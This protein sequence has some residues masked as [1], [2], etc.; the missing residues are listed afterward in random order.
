MLVDG[1]GDDR[2]AAT[3]Y[4]QGAGFFGIG[5]LVDDGGDDRYDAMTFAQA[6]GATGGL[7]ALLEERG[8]DTYV[9]AG[10]PRDFRE[11]DHAQSFGQ[12]FAMGIR[13][14]AS[15]GIGLLAD[16]AGNDR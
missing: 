13:P 7:G 11:P 12:G 15:G 6:F 3:A 5:V 14:V 4:A 2:Y 1:G 8:D 16:H 9:L 10:G